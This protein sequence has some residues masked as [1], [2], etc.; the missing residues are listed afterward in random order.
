AKAPAQPDPDRLLDEALVQAR[1]AF[2]RKD[3][4]RFEL[5]AAVARNH[6]LAEYLDFWRLRMRLHEDSPEAGTGLV[7]REVREFLT[8]HPDTV[9]GDLMCRDW[10]FDLARRG[11]W[12]QFDRQYED[13][14]LRDDDQ[15]HC[16]LWL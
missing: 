12:S 14:V 3:N 9:A 4:A 7:D 1:Q 6:P 5:A 11:E 2:V 15:L 13:W 10:M 8:A 16:H